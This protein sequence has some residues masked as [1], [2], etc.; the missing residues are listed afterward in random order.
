VPSAML[1]AANRL[2]A[3]VADVVVGAF[4]RH[5]GHHRECRLRPAQR[6]DLDLGFLVDGQHHGSLGRVEVE[7]DDVVDLVHEHRVVGQLNPSVRCGLR[8]N[9]F[10]IRPIVDLESPLRSAIFF[11]DQ[12]VACSGVDSR[13][14][15]TTSSTC[16]AVI[17]G[18][19]PDRGSSTKPSSLDSTNRD[20]HFP[21][22]ASKPQ[23]AQRLPCSSNQS[24][25]PK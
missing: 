1:N 19:R 25:R 9:P 16:S 2:V 7:P 18:L 21:P 12:W 22:S 3:G 17:V 11:R 13:V 23:A 10:Q 8:L 14:A 15:T 4:L 24:R 6:L 5:I 20:R